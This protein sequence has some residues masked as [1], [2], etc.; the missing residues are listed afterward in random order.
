[1]IEGAI[2][3]FKISSCFVWGVLVVA[4]LVSGLLIMLWNINLPKLLKYIYRLIAIIGLITSWIIMS[5]VVNPISSA[6]LLLIIVVIVTALHYYAQK[7]GLI[8][9]YI[10]DVQ[11]QREKL[12][13]NA[14]NIVLD[15]SYLYYQSMIFAF[16][17][18][19]DIIPIK[20][21]EN[22]KIEIVNAIIKVFN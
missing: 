14:E 18:E 2:A 17:L 3:Y 8:R 7:Y 13:K 6:F 10:K 1:L 9:Y 20:K 11:Q 12:V 4:S 15:K 22:Y 21:D 16:D 19:K 5:A